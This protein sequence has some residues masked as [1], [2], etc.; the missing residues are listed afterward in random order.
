MA[1]WM[2]FAWVAC[3]GAFGA[4]A[5]YGT[6]LLAQKW[7]GTSYPWG[8]VIANMIGCFLMGTLFALS[9]RGVAIQHEHAKL[10]LMV[11]FLGS[12]TT[13]SSFALDNVVLAKDQTVGTMLFN[14][15]LQNILGVALVALAIWL[16]H[17]LF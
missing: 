17:Q 14:V 15:G 11:G 6:G 8:T 5:R 10:L 13:F 12:F 7:V 9:T 2:K 4:M 3:G 1:M 16:V